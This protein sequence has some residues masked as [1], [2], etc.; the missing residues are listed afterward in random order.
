MPLYL[1]TCVDENAKTITETL[2]AANV[3]ALRQIVEAKRLFLVSQREANRKAGGGSTRLSMKI[4]RDLF[5]VIA[6]QLRNNVMTDVIIRKLKENFPNAAARKVLRGIDHELDISRSTLTDAMARYPRSFNEG[7]IES[8]RV[9]EGSGV[10]ALAE[11]FADLRDQ[12][13]FRLEIRGTVKKALSYPA[14]IGTMACG[15]LA[16]VMLVVIPKLQALLTMLHVPL[17]ALTRA[18][19]GAS[20]FTVNHWPL[21]LGVA[22]GLVVLWRVLRKAEPAAVAMDLVFIRIPVIGYIIKSLVTAEVSKIYR[23][24]YRAGMPANETLRACAA[25][26]SNKA[27]KAAIN[28][29]REKLESG[30]LNT[31]DAE[32]YAI[33]SAL[34]ETGYFPDMALTIIQ[35]GEASGGLVEALDS[36]AQK[37]ADEAKTRIRT[38]LAVFEKFTMVLIVAGVGVIIVACMQPIFTITQNIR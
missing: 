24:L 36:V 13:D 15:L 18:V 14:M 30:I 7:V 20:M 34:S 33:T 25:V 2:E 16:F 8:I 12:I 37:Y 3:T 28:R 29:S 31:G 5:D 11:R 6:L 27:A 9:S 32:N 10:K 1:A 38:L 17:P 35:S 23:A 21:L 4:Q 19:L 22:V 26:M